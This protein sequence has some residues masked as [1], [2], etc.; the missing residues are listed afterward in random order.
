MRNTFKL[1]TDKDQVFNG[2][3]AASDCQLSKIDWV[4]E[5]DP[6]FAKEDGNIYFREV[7]DHTELLEEAAAKM[8]WIICCFDSEDN[9]TSGLR[10]WLTKYKAT[11]K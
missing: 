3:W 10:E 4:E 7:P 5:S 9:A 8:R 1:L 11:L 6:V 2:D